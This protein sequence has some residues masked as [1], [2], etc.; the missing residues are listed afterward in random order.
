MLNDRVVAITQDE[1]VPGVVDQILDSNVLTARLLNNVKKWNGESM[2]VPII[3]AKNA[4]GGSFSGSDTFTTGLEA[5][6]KK[7]RFYPKAYYQ[8]V[9]INGIEKAVNKTA[10][11][12]ASLVA[13]QMEAA[14]NSMVDSL[15]TILYGDG[16]GN[17]GKNFDGLKAIADDGTVVATYGG[18]TRASNTYLNASVTTAVGTLALS[19]LRTSLRNASAASASKS[20]PNIAITTE[21]IWDA[22]E[23]LFPAPAAQ[24]QSRELPRL[25]ATGNTPAMSDTELRGATGYTAL[26]FKATP[27]VADDLAPTGELYLLNENH[28]SFYH[29][30]DAD[31]D[32]VKR[33]SAITSSA[34]DD[35]AG[36]TNFAPIQWTGF[37][38]PTDQYSLVGQLLLLGNTISNK[39]RRN[40]R[41]SGITG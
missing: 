4:N 26:Y 1:I 17:S 10:A 29:L 40:A 32:K 20:R 31:L 38:K 30:A 14:Q 23:N 5:N 36:V 33:P 6:T 37:L 9:S 39:P 2:V 35:Q 34:N 27:I 25:T 22:I 16:T 8:N 19:N 18:L 15:G 41:L 28:Q 21:L 7:M 11:Q 12:Q 3:S 24:F 13:V